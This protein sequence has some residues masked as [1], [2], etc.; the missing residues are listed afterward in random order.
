MKNKLTK[1]E[2]LGLAILDDIRTGI[3]CTGDELP[4]I[5]ELCRRYSM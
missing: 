2:Q 1:V 3:Y 4:S 5:R